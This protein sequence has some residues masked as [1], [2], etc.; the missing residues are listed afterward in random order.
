MPQRN[1]LVIWLAL[2]A[3]LIAMLLAIGADA[4]PPLP[5]AP[6]PRTTTVTLAWDASPEAARYRVYWGP[7]RGAYTN[8]LETPQC[9]ATISGLVLPQYFAAT[10]IGTNGLESEMSNEVGGRPIIILAPQESRDAGASWSPL[11]PPREIVITNHASQQAW[12]RLR[13]TPEWR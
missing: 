10:C 1:Y 6:P 7:S 9:S 2:G 4:P 13:I 12:F 3:L 8:H 5:I 11:D